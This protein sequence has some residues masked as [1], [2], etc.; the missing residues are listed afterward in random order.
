MYLMAISYKLCIF[1]SL[2]IILCQPINSQALIIFI[3]YLYYFFIYQSEK[4]AG[5]LESLNSTVW[6]RPPYRQQSL[7][8]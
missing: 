3:F 8:S 5:H 7:D 2:F 6:E 4:L 1:Y